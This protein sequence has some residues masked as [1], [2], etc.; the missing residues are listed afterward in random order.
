ML[1]TWLPAQTGNS[2]YAT[3]NADLVVDINGYYVQASSIQGP[4]CP[5][6][7]QGPTG[8][9][10]PTGPT[11]PVGPSGRQGYPG[12]VMASMELKSSLRTARGRLLKASLP[13]WSRCG[14]GEGGGGA[15]RN[16]DGKVQ[17]TGGGEGRGYTRAVIPVT[18]SF[19][20]T[21]NPVC[22]R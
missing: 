17:Q 12:P 20:Y 22:P 11:G 5:A 2:V 16:C 7:P 15:A 1:S 3:D 13:S 8:L 19:I 4:S 6:G 18:S 14:A 10:G 9:R 21:Q